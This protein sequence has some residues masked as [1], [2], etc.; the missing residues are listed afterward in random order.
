M[1]ELGLDLAS[2]RVRK[3]SDY[4][5]HLDFRLRWN[6]NDIFGHMNN[7]YYGVLIDSIV[8]QYMIEECGYKLN[9][10]EQAGIIANTYCDYFG[11]VSY[12]DVVDCGLRI[13]KLGKASVMYE[14]GIFRR[15]EDDVKAVGGSTHVYVLQK[16]GQL[17]KPDKD[18]MPKHMREG[19]ERLMKGQGAAKL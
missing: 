18:G 13:V 16:D 5:Y 19:Y 9:K 7:P 2:K 8:N 15:G 4:G 11:S 10:G 14:V 3:R 12:P 1:P 6:D 17:G